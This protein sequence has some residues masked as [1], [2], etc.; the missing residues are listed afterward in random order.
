[1]GDTK[2]DVCNLQA[3]DETGKLRDFTRTCNEEGMRV[4]GANKLTITEEVT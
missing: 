1:M 2:P 4:E 3:C